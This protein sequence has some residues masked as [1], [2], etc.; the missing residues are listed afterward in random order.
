MEI[1]KA[2]AN[3]IYKYLIKNKCTVSGALGILGNL[4]CES[5]LSSINLENTYNTKFG[6]TDVEYTDAVDNGS[7][8]NFVKDSAGYGLAQWT[9][10]SRK[11]ALLDFAQSRSASIGDMDMQLDYL[12]KELKTNYKAVWDK[13]TT[14]KD[15]FECVSY[16][17]LNFERPANQSES[18][19]KNRYEITRQIAIAICPKDLNESV[20]PSKMS[21]WT[22]VKDFV[23]G[24]RVQIST[25]FVSTEFDCHG[26]GCCN[27]TPIDYDLI[28]ILQNVRTHFNKPVTVNCGYR[29]QIGRAHV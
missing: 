3:K 1:N 28:K 21:V 2:V 18:A 20:S 13:M 11:Q 19:Q 12:V 10:W 7:Y 5:G 25:N 15:L 14:S 6:M 22:G 26:V 9:Y 16:F 24:D 4:Y 29:C 8:K 17:M 27:S 23:K